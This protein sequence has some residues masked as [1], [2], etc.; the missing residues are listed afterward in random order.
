MTEM[1]LSF[2][3]NY[4][5]VCLTIDDPDIEETREMWKVLDEVSDTL[6]SKTYDMCSG[7]SVFDDIELTDDQ[8]AELISDAQE[9][10]KDV[11][12]NANIKFEYDHYST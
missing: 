6:P 9:I 3:T 1:T 5:G 11:F 12:P 4:N 2:A 8:I 10:I 7:L